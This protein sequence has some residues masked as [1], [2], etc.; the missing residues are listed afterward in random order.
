MAKKQ[1]ITTKIPIEPSHLNEY[2]PGSLQLPDVGDIWGENNNDWKA[3]YL[4]WKNHGYTNDGNLII[5][6]LDLQQEIS[7]K[8]RCKISFY[9]KRVHQG[10]RENIIEG[11]VITDV[12]QFHLPHEWELKSKFITAEGKVVPELNYH[13]KAVVESEKIIRITNKKRFVEEKPEQ[14]IHE[15]GLIRYLFEPDFN[16]ENIG[17]F[18]FLENGLIPKSGHIIS[19]TPELNQTYEN[20]QL[21]CYVQFGYA[22]NPIE[23]YLDENNLLCAAIST[24]SAKICNQHAAEYY[25]E[26]VSKSFNN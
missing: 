3:S 19:A 6:Y 25:N 7:R 4:I 16:I 26:F 5:G 2:S 13:Q 8:K 1:R 9:E 24:F 21:K 11:H 10:G 23:Y 15:F 17:S 22:I 18:T 20:R 12:S 14:V